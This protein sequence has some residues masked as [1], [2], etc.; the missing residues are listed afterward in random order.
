MTTAIVHYPEKRKALLMK[1]GLLDN[2]KVEIRAYVSKEKH[3]I[4]KQQPLIDYRMAK[5]QIAG[6]QKPNSTQLYNWTDGLDLEERKIINEECGVQF[7]NEDSRVLLRHGMTLDLSIPADA[8]LWNFIKYNPILGKR[9]ADCRNGN[10]RFYVYDAVAVTSERSNNRSL[11][12]KALELYQKLTPNQMR[13]CLGLLGMDTKVMSEMEVK[14]T[15]GEECEENYKTVLDRWNAEDKEHR[16]MLNNLIF[17]GVLTTDVET[18]RIMRNGNIFAADVDSALLIIKDPSNSQLM[19]S[20]LAD[21]RNKVMP[22]AK[23]TTRKTTT[24]K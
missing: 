18:K 8:A 16:V 15:F 4:N 17:N 24:K 1:A 13:E 9:E 2:R 12:I 3:P 19:K 6:T 23:S 10:I 21:L 5:E 7:Y 22:I 11:K 14:D 20:L